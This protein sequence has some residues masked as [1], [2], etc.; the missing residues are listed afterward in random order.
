MT[1]TLLTFL[2]LVL[3]LW[4]FSTFASSAELSKESKLAEGEY[5]VEGPDGEF[6]E[7]WIL[8]ASEQGYR[9]NAEA[10]GELP[11]ESFAFKTE[12]WLAKNL[13]LARWEVSMLSEETGAV[14]LK[15][16]CEMGAGQLRCWRRDEEAT[17]PW[18]TNAEVH[19]AFQPTFWQFTSMVNRVAGECTGIPQA[20]I[21]A[22]WDVGD[23][24]SD[25]VSGEG[26]LRCLGAA[27]VRLMGAE[28]PATKWVA[29]P[30]EDTDL[31]ESERPSGSM[32]LWVLPEGLVALAEVHD[33]GGHRTAFRLVRYE[34]YAEFGPGVE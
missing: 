8:Y 6:H 7:G 33:E 27:T 24:P 22:V 30:S 31:D 20:V 11:R 14:D 10:R 15:F 23:G 2:C 3:S 28:V 17:I 18:P 26:A 13:T 25:I 12:Y 34:K 21:S 19:P 1:R 4:G 16:G 5:L 29:K 32:V 9:V